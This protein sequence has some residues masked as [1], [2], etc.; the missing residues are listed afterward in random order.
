MSEKALDLIWTKM[1]DELEEICRK[2][3]VMGYSVRDLKT[4]RKAGFREDVLFPTA[5]T[6]KIHILLGVAIRVH[7]GELDW[8]QRVVVEDEDKVG[9]S[10]VLATSPTRLTSPCGMWQPL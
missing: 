10:G 1:A 2:T 3:G 9:G 6:I 5:S 7:R 8:A 4:G